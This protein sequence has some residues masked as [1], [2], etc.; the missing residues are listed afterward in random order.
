MDDIFDIRFLIGVL[1]RRWPLIVIPSIIG[2]LI[3]VT[4]AMLLPP[5]YSST[6]RILVES[7]QIPSELVRSTVAGGAAERIQS[8]EQRLMTRQNLLEMAGRFAVFSNRGDLSPTDIVNRMRAATSIRAVEGTGGRR[9]RSNATVTTVEISFRSDR[10]GTAAEV[11]GEFLTQVLQQ[12]VEQR[13]SRAAETADFFNREVERL[14]FEL[15]AIEDR[16]AAFKRENAVS[17]PEALDGVRNELTALRREA[18]A[19]D[20]QRLA[21]T[22]AKRSLEAAIAAGD[23]FSAEERRDPEVV[24]LQRLRRELVQQRAIFAET[25]PSVRAL[26]AQISALETRLDPTILSGQDDVAPG[27]QEPVSSARR[28]IDRIEAE[29]VLIDEQEARDEARIELLE[30]AIVRAP[31]VGA[32]LGALNR[33]YEALQVQYREAVQKQA[34]AATGER[35]EVNQQAERFEVIERPQVPD[36]PISPN[37]PRI[38]VAGSVVSVGLGVALVVL[39]EMLNPALR[40]ARS[41]ERVLE[42]RPI[43]MIPYLS[44]AQEQRR[45]RWLLRILIAAMVICIPLAIYAVDRFYLPLPL[46]LEIVMQR[47]GGAE[48][49][50]IVNQRF[51]L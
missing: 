30:A 43:V 18:F 26:T 8:I 1:K 42:I 50:S 9:T 37:R 47:T 35:L 29:I 49:L 17:L 11:A 25:H 31:E 45:R 39:V 51:G 7:Q 38:A 41:M 34:D 21:L 13:S 12:N 33:Q 10:P 6:A 24:E 36:R 16:I 23:A 5:V 28:E 19:R 22:N 32:N 4:V 48:I 20:S 3:T 14:S 44:S 40:S 15:S 46:L 27:S 2:V